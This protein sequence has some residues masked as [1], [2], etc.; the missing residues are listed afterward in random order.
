M[1][2][3]NPLRILLVDDSDI[4]RMSVAILLETL[5][6]VVVV[7]EA[8]NGQTAVELCRRLRP[9]IVLMD[10]MMPV[11]DGITATRLICQEH[12]RVTII[13][14]TSALDSSMIDAALKAGASAYLHKSAS[15][16]EI[17][18]TIRSLN[19]PDQPSDTSMQSILKPLQ[20][21]RDNLAAVLPVC[22][23]TPS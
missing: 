19:L 14:L 8:N 20:S 22:R 5:D 12:A 23:P 16:D 21:V 11:M 3:S 10:L 15:I 17:I 7:G 1:R 2:H 9:D 13:A 4:V 18:R 6:D